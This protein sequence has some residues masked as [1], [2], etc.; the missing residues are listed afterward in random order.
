MKTEEEIKKELEIMI[1]EQEKE[2][3]P[4]TWKHITGYIGALRWILGINRPDN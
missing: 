3:N 1:K 2:R 4:D